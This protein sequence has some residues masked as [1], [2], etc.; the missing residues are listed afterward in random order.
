MNY[1][2]GA[3][4]I[5][6]N[7]L[8]SLCY[9]LL[10]NYVLA[11]I[12][13][14]LLTKIILLPVSLWMQRNSIRMVELTPELNHLKIKYYGDKETIAE[15][16]QALYKRK[17]YHQFASMLPMVIQLV[18]LVGVIGA[19]RSLLEGAESILSAYPTQMG[20]ITL[21]MPVAAG[22]A[23]LLLGLAQ[24]R[25]N[26]LQ[27]EQGKAE[28]WM[29]N[30]ISILIS[31]VLGTFVPLG[32]GVY[33]ITSNLLTILQQL[34]LNTIINPEKYLDYEQLHKSRDELLKMNSLSSHVSK[35]DKRR[36][37]ADYKRFFSIANK[38]LVFY[39][40]SSGFYKYF[41]NVIEEL[42]AHSNIVVHYIT[43][44]PKDQI[45]QIAKQQPRI[46][47]YYIGEKR[48]ITLMMKMDAD[49]VVMTMPDLDNFHIKRSYVKKDVEYVY[50]FHG[51]I[52]GM[53]TLRP[54]ALDHF[55]TLLSVGDYLDREIRMLEQRNCTKEKRIVPCGYGVVDNMAAAYEQM[56]QKKEGTPYILIAPS[57][58][59]DNIL[60]SCLSSLCQQLLETG[61]RVIVR[62]HPQYLRRF[63][64]KFEQI[65]H[66]CAK[67]PAEQF[68]MQTDFSS[69]ETVF[70]AALLVTDW[71][72]IG[73]EYALA[74]KKPVL[75]INTPMKVVNPQIAEM[76]KDYEPFD[77]QMRKV[78]GTALEIDDVARN[79]GQTAK[80]LIS[81]GGNYR[82]IIQNVREKHVY[83]FGKSGQYGARYIINS[84]RDRKG[85][86]HDRIL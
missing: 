13:F 5:P 74:T 68:Q 45:F 86:N 22:G 25:F 63:P 33:W 61:Y 23:A 11:I 32:V 1:I 80:K 78:M 14:T 55:D 18:L 83:N 48:L 60:E 57:W 51:V 30:G 42:I 69:N 66:E 77:L 65:E 17:H 49:I 53:R 4:A 85:K 54:G 29:T 15:E 7:A 9:Q 71:S 3:L 46:K 21:L 31:L 73:Y 76:E 37:K 50:M 35:E 26:P 84:L 64:Q 56:E 67:F 44:D 39:S 2:T 41:Q 72:S 79:A 40:E 34:L 58:Q 6:L 81:E 24:N 52:S 12:G 47:P 27:R 43:S 62:P 28:Q 36:E 16:T 70:Q 8:M 38:H 10:G 19:V 59:E 75:F 20:G 82:E